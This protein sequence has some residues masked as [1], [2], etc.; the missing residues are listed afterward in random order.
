MSDKSIE[1]VI[2]YLLE[3][4]KILHSGDAREHAYRPAFQKLIENLALDIQVI[5]EPAYTG[6]NAPDFLFKKGDTPIAYAECKDVTIDID[7]RYVQ[8]QAKR[9][10]EAFGRI[11]LTNYYD[12]QIINESGEVVKISIAEMADGKIVPQS[13]NFESF[14]NLIRDYIT[15]SHRT[16][17]SAKKLAEIMASKA[18]IL[19]DNALASLTEN[20][21]SDIYAQ[22]ITFKEILIR[23]LTEKDFADMYA[24]TLVYGLFVARYFDLTLKTFSRH[25]AQDLLPSTNPLLKKFFGHVAGTD[26]DPKIAWLVDS[27]IEAYLSTD[28]HE[29]MH[30]EFVTKQKDPVLHFYETFLTK[31]DQGLRKKRGVYYTPEPVVSFIVRSVD[32]ILK[33]KFNLPKGLADNSKIEHKIKVQAEDKRTKD[34]IKKGTEKIH[35]VQILDPAVGTGTFLNEV[36]HEI[37]KSFKGQEGMWQG[38]AKDHLLPRLHGFELMMASYTMAHLKLGVTLA[39]LGYKGKERLSVW[40]TNSLEK[41]VHE[42]P[43]LFMSQ[44]LTEES[45][46]ASWI[47]SELP[48][49]VVLGNPPYSGESFNKNNT[50]HNVYKVEPG[51]KQ[52]LQEQNSKWLNDD[53]VKFIRFAESQVEKTGEGV[54]SFITPHGYLDNPTFRGMRWHLMK[55][56][57][58]IYVL[59]LH[60]NANKKEKTPEGAKDENVFGIKTGT[61]I[62]L[63]IKNNDNNR[64]L[65]KVFHADFYG[66]QKD[67]YR[68]LN[69]NSWESIKWKKLSPNEPS[70]YFVPFDDEKKKKYDEGFSVKDLFPINGV[71]MTTAHDDFVIK[72]DKNELLKMYEDFQSTRRDA[73]LL[74]EKFN[75][76]KKT[77]WN[78]LDGY[79]S[80]KN[81]EDL[82][83][84]IYPISYRPFDTRYV[85]YEDRLIWRTVRRVMQPF[86]DGANVGLVTARTNK[87][88]NCDHFFVSKYIM[89]TKCGERTTQSSIFPLYF[90]DE[91]V[92]KIPN[93]DDEI[94]LKIA[95]KLNMRPD[96]IPECAQAVR[97]GES[98]HELDSL[99]TFSPEDMLDYIYAVLHSP[100]YREKY[101]EFLK[102]DFPRVLYPKD[103]EIFWK[104]VELGRELQGLHLL[105]SPKVSDFITTFPIGGS[106][107]VEKRY[108]KFEDGKVFLNEIQYFGN[109]TE[110]AW[111]FYIG[112][113]QPA[114]KWLK[115]RR[116]RELSTEDIEHY[117]QM[118]VALSDTGRIMGEI[119][120]VIKI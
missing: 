25:E 27:L 80:I 84:Y 90:Y 26:Y 18:R 21:D 95:N 72:K 119:D 108:P 79:D 53:Y 60:G 70:L 10:V 86:L 78:I 73:D 43:N 91:F 85:F 99:E 35:K 87:S 36:I 102:I 110:V 76:K 71:G 116:E 115:D 11:L 47:K 29:L 82:E 2:N 106:N 17:R 57:D 49:M 9:Y 4:E 44:W 54:V 93:L 68:Q 48:I 52:K 19:R 23:D 20:P 81:E 75:V 120:G 109:V 62:L 111:N 39:E 31:Y 58:E 32:Q 24:Q 5:N 103:K 104:L 113:Y 83:T 41:G 63:A 40:L 34:N 3:I 67:K 51:G 33:T 101:K 14:V 16:I 105:E 50:G 96:W 117:Q 15:P 38:Y 30:K 107:I 64:K 28:V 98:A 114:Q 1:I 100:K 13:T 74:H 59:D 8:K 77:G 12:F 42:F 88:E 56:F 69:E 65:A 112:G 92:G 46:Q 97:E 94:V 37:H 6:G 55:T 7:H 22:Y 45:H 118:I 66:K 89:E 61:T